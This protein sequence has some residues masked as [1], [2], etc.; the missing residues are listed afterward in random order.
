MDIVEKL[1]RLSMMENNELDNEI[2]KAELEYK[3]I[4]GDNDYTNIFD[5]DET[6]LRKLRECIK[7]KISYNDLHNVKKRKEKLI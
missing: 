4:F 7:F 5:D 6:Y 1:H 3:E 2:E